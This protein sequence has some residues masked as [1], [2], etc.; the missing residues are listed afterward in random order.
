[1]GLIGDLLFFVGIPACFIGAAA[2]LWRDSR[3]N[4][5]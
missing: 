5:P 2:L 3:S 4:K 1:M